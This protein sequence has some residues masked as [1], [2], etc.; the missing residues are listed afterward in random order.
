MVNIIQL[1]FG[2]DS[3][4]GIQKT[5]HQNS[6]IVRLVNPKIQQIVVIVQM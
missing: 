2:F 1:P 6:T 5:K 3:K 4:W